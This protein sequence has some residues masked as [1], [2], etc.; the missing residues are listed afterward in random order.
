MT[1][2]KAAQFL[3]FGLGVL[4]A[5]GA[6]T[7]CSRASE[8]AP[9]A[10]ESRAVGAAPAW[11]ASAAG[12]VKDAVEVQ[13]E[14]ADVHTEIERMQGRQQLLDKKSAFSRLT[15]HLS[16]AVPVRETPTLGITN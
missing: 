8:A 14:L 10:A 4:I 5:A 13:K 15:V 3:V 16:S 1:H 11:A 6:A 12:P 9:P 2:S 7:G